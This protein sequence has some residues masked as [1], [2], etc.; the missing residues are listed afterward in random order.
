MLYF[1]GKPINPSHYW[2]HEG[3]SYPSHFY[4]HLPDRVLYLHIIQDGI[5]T[6]FGDILSGDLKLVPY[7][8]SQDLGSSPPDGFEHAPVWNEVFVITQYWGDAFFHKML[9]SLPRIAP[10]IEFLQTNKHIKVHVAE[11]HGYTRTSLK[12]LGIGS[13][14]IISGPSRA[15]LVYL[16]QATACGFTQVQEI[17]MLSHL[18]RQQIAGWGLGLRNLVVLIQRTGLRR[19][20]KWEEVAFLVEKL[21]GEFGFEYAVFPDNPSPPM[22]QAMQTFYQAVMVVAPHGAGLANVVYSQP[23]TFVIEG[24]CNP[25]HVN[26]CFQWTSHVLGHRYHGIPSRGGCE[27]Y[28]DVEPQVLAFLMRLYLEQIKSLK[29]E[30]VF[31]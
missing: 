15:K 30:N 7:S 29:V 25:P 18:Y 28:V 21:S 27:D 17:Q 5:I 6:V 26:M 31:T 4:T 13:E 22:E 23:G 16:P 3:K 10:Y 19:F 14:R 12:F 11:S 20:M 1:Y 8:C 9:E 2:P 24:V